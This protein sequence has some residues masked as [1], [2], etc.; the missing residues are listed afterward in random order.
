VALAHYLVSRLE[1]LPEVA[2]RTETGFV[3][4][5][6]IAVITIS[7]QYGSY[8]DAVAE[9]LC[10]RL[11]CRLLDRNLLRRFAVEAA[12]EPKKVI[13]LSEDR[14]RPRTPLERLWANSAPPTRNPVLWAEY[15]SAGARNH[16]AA[17]RLAQLMQ[18]AYGRGNVVIVGRGG[19]VVLRDRPDVLHARLT[20]P[21]AVRVRRHQVRAGLTVE[22][23]Q[24]AVLE[25][26]AA[27]AE[28]MKRYF[29]V[30]IDDPA[31][32]DLILNTGKLSWEAAA[33]LIIGALAA[34]PAGA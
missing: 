2:C 15:G 18:A 5:E 29:D 1:G 31:L 12:L 28:F 16:A 21:L 22:A 26:D 7:A 10:D 34:L 19:Q 24:A 32:Y 6:E 13:D 27:S 11:G 17:E 14:Y 4:E 25:R 23:A 3:G 30:N 8:G 9:S 33:D 20:A